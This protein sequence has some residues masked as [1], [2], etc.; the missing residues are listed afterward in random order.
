MLGLDLSG[1]VGYTD[2]LIN[3]F[4]DSMG[5]T[6]GNFEGNFPMLGATAKLFATLSGDKFKWTPYVSGAVDY[7]PGV[8]FTLTTPPQLLVPT[9]DVQTYLPAPTFWIGEL[10]LDVQNNAGWS[11]GVKGY[12]MASSD[13]TVRYIGAHL[14]IPLDFLPLA[15]TGH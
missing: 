4:T 5:L 8:S 12:Y 1:H 6:S 11:V 14:T 2:F 13:T 9:G 3:G 7:Y 10:G 15:S